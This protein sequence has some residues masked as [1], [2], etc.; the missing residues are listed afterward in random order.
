ML[1]KK[2][3]II[4]DEPEI[5]TIVSQYLQVQGYSTDIADTISSCNAY[6]ERE[7]PDFII[8]DLTLPDGD[9]IELCRRLRANMLT[10]ILVLSARSSDTDKVLA[11]GFGADDYMTKPFS[12][13]ELAARI[14]AHLR[15]LNGIEAAAL[16]QANG[17]SGGQSGAPAVSAMKPLPQLQQSS[18]T[19][20]N[21]IM[22]TA[23]DANATA[24]PAPLAQSDREPGLPLSAP[25]STGQTRVKQP[26]TAPPATEQTSIC[27]GELTIDKRS[28]KVKLNNQLITLSAKEFDLL[29]FLASNPEQVFTKTQLLDQ[30]W[31]F[32]SYV[33]DNTVTV[34]IGRLRSKLEPQAAKSSYIK[35][36]WGVGYQFSPDDEKE[37][38]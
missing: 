30:V 15:R 4:E 28:R 35:T 6:L 33:D 22:Q 36:V 13:S 12:L 17:G 1:G 9:G 8:L 16:K 37:Q 5:A 21:A 25:A 3:L 11:L 38:H 31:G 20:A 7:A 32:S 29:Y 14:Q 34:Y 2:V 19:S 18:F 27:A 23:A 26:L 10:P 24:W